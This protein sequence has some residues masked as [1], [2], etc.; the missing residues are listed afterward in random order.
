MAAEIGELVKEVC[1]DEK[2]PQR[3]FTTPDRGVGPDSDCRAAQ[4]WQEDYYSFGFRFSQKGAQGAGKSHCINIRRR[5]F[6]ECLGWEDGVQFQFLAQ[7]NT[8]AAL[9][10]GKTVNTWG[11]IPITFRSC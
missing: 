8:M 9:I 3:K 1:S 4:T 5:F 6:E 7:Q 11:V 2:I 10:G